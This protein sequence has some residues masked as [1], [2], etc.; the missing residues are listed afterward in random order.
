MKPKNKRT[1]VSWILTASTYCSQYLRRQTQHKT[2]FPSFN[3]PFTHS[4]V[5]LDSN[6]FNSTGQGRSTDLTRFFVSLY[7]RYEKVNIAG[8][9]SWSWGKNNVNNDTGRLILRARAGQ[10]GSFTSFFVFLEMYSKQWTER[11]T[12]LKRGQT[13]RLAVLFCLF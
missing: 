2:K 3:D 9:Y 10:Y 4:L 1:Y 13:L 5:F 11:T 12:C 6:T 7:T 8:G